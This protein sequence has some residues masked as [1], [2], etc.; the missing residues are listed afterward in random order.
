MKNCSASVLARMDSIL[1]MDAEYDVHM[2]SFLRGLGIGKGE[3][4]TGRKGGKNADWFPHVPK[5]PLSQQCIVYPFVS[6]V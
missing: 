5:S 3:E 1:D 2:M 6:S 4:A